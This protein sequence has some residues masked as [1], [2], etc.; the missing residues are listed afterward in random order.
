MIRQGRKSFLDI[1]IHRGTQEIGGSCVQISSE[2]RSIL[3]D[4]GSPLGESQS[5]VNLS[6]INFDAVL[7]SHPHQDHYGLIDN[8]DPDVPVYIGEIAC[9]MIAAARV[10][11]GREPLKNNFKHV[12]AWTPFEI[13]PF[14]I[15]PYLMDHSSVDSFGFLIEAEGKKVFY[16]GD[17]R[18]HGSKEKSFEAFLA[19]PPR[20][21]DLLL[22]EGTMMGRENEAFKREKD[23]EDEMLEVFNNETG[24]AFLIC[25]GQHVDRLCAAF[26]ACRRA[27]RVF[28]VDIYTA[29]ILQILSE[30][31]DTTPHFRLEDIRVLAHGGTA[32]THYLSIKDNTYFDNFLREIYRRDNVITEA[33]IGESPGR[34][35]IKSCRVD[36]LLKTLNPPQCSLIY[37]QWRGYLEDKYNPQSW[38]LTRLRDDPRVS[39]HEIHTSGHAFTQDLKRFADAISPKLLV[40]IHTE[41]KDDYAK[42]FVPNQVKSVA[43]GEPFQI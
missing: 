10:F 17:F 22:M 18:A 36:L 41:K 8:L 9:K 21:V 32:R 12:K 20:N 2:G 37:S 35:L 1:T 38:K 14:R 43:D 27:G 13:A 30:H 29:W 34:Y 23:V 24:P 42:H 40:P 25:S 39:F 16:S 26:S 19:R 6:D 4:A 7:V 33:Q 28:V 15:T 5:E 11:T 3:I 31:F